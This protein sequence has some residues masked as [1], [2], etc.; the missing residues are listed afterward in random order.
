MDTYSV[1]DDRGRLRFI[2]PPQAVSEIGGTWTLLNDATFREQWLFVY[3]Y[4]DYGRMSAEAVPG[5]GTTRMIYDRWGRLVYSQS[6]LMRAQNPKQW[7]YTKYDYLDRP[8][9][10]GVFATATS[11]E[12]TLRAVLRITEDRFEERNSSAVG[13]TLGNSYPKSVSEGSLRSVSYYDDYNFPSAIASSLDFTDDLA[14][15]TP[16]TNMKGEL[17]GSLTRNLTN[18]S[19]LGSVIYYDEQYRPIVAVTENHLGGIDRTT[20]RYTSSVLDEVE[21]TFTT[22]TTTAG[23]HTVRQTYDYDHQG[24][25]REVTHQLDNQRP[26]VKLAR[27]TYNELGQLVQQE[28]NADAPDEQVSQTVDYRY[29]VRGWL[30]GIND[31]NEADDYF[32]Q[33]LVYER[34]GNQDVVQFNGNVTDQ[35]WRNWGQDEQSYQYKYDEADRLINAVHSGPYSTKSIKYDGNGNLTDLQ[36][37]TQGTTAPKKMDFLKYSYQ[38]NRLTK[39]KERNG[40]DLTLGF[41]DGAN[42]NNEYGYDAAGN[43]VRDDNK[44]ITNIVYDPVLNLPLEVSMSNGMLR[45]GYDAAGN[46]LWQQVLNGAGEVVVT[47]DYVGA[48]EYSNST[49]SLVHHGEGRIHFPANQT[50]GQYHFDLTDHLGNVRAT[51]SPVPIITRTVATME[52]DPEVQF[53]EETRFSN[54]GTRHLFAFH[55]TTPFSSASPAPDRVAA[56]NQTQPTGPTRSLKVHKGDKV[57]LWINA[58]YEE[59]IPEDPNANAMVVAGVLQ[60]L[61]PGAQGEGVLRAA[62]EGARALATGGA[63]A[64]A[65]AGGVPRGSLNLLFFDENYVEDPNQRQARPITT[66]ALVTATTP[67]A[68]QA[69]YIEVDITQNGYVSAYPSNESET[70]VYFDDFVVEHQTHLVQVN[71]YYPFGARHDQGSFVADHAKYGYQGK[72]LTSDLGLNLLDFHARQYDPLLGRFH[73]SDPMAMA[74]AGMSPYAGMVGNPVSYVDPDGRLP[75]LVPILIGVA[76]G[77][78]GGYQAGKAQGATGWDLFAYTALGAGIGAASGGI[79]AGVSAGVGASVS[80]AYGGLIGAVSG[81]AAAGAFNGAAMAGLAGGN[82]I[83]GFW[84]GGVSGLVGAGVGSY[85][86]GGVGALAG[87]FAGGGTSAAL[88]GGDA[89]DI[90]TSGL[91]GGAIAYGSY[92]A[93]MFEAYQHSDKSFNYKQFRKISVATQRSFARG[94]EHGGWITENDV[95]INPKMGEIDYIPNDRWAP[96]PDNAIADFHTHPNIGSGYTANFSGPDIQSIKSGYTLSQLN[97]G[98]STDHYVISR[99]NMTYQLSGYGASIGLNRFTGLQRFLSLPFFP[100]SI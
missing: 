85:I 20:T 44:G 32:S 59:P 6:A 87:G 47:T 75:I 9:L 31:V 55:N 41:V 23:S 36:R 71:D 26:A 74:V 24:R 82:A 48:F 78:F 30:K 67:T 72:E 98:P 7:V 40:G 86:G 90:L 38:G 46:R 79:G 45:Y 57:R 34:G 39:V 66:D 5:G 35:Y 8:V 94:R 17:T 100:V 49:L 65:E 28:I 18:D 4:D 69:I 50:A 91:I 10:S 95:V 42:S 62:S 68:V 22:H 88:Y 37:F 51:F 15:H 53:Y 61:T 99:Q 2:I 13:Y 56:L 96:R 19:W 70:W 76:V 25:L 92:Q 14:S 11:D 80:G 63:M 58:R 81:G 33:E 12:A 97:G 16:R 84:K 1:Y 27:Y 60:S 73:S 93:S 83:E 64:S 3:S 52:Q 89:G 29:H 77:G 54:M 21:E 43:L